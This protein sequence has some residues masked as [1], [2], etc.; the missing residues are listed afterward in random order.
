MDDQHSSQF[1]GATGGNADD[2]ERLE[3]KKEEKEVENRRA[4]YGTREEGR[5]AQI[6]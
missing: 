2:E 6:Q 5:P 1:Q 4:P 3:A